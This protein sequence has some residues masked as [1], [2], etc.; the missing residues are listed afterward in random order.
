MLQNFHGIMPTYHTR[1]PTLNIPLLT[2]DCLSRNWY[3][4]TQN[5][6][7]YLQPPRPTHSVSNLPDL[8]T[9]SCSA[10]I[11]LVI[12]VGLGNSTCTT[13][14]PCPRVPVC[15]LACQTSPILNNE[16]GIPC[17]YLHRIQW[18]TQPAGLFSYRG[19]YCESPTNMSLVFFSLPR[20]SARFFT[21][22]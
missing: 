4:P 6:V 10:E 20:D 12:L 7:T 18:H 17:A 22:S 9:Q 8:P 2:C 15:Y 14:S 1:Q 13:N 21:A 19:S 16:S 5:S 11:S 3:L